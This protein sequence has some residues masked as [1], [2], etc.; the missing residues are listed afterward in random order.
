MSRLESAQVGEV[1]I[2][3]VEFRIDYFAVTFHGCSDDDVRGWLGEAFGPDWEPAGWNPVLQDDERMLKVQ[4]PHGAYLERDRSRD[5]VHVSLKGQACAAIGTEQLLS[6]A[7]ASRARCGGGF[8]P[9][10]VD[11]AWD[12]HAKRIA[13][14]EFA[15][16]VW[17]RNGTD[18]RPEV[19]SKARKGC[20]HKNLGDAK[21]ACCELGTRTSERMMRY[22]DKEA[23]SNGAVK[24]MR[25][26]LQTRHRAADALLSALIATESVSDAVSAAVSHLVGFVDFREVPCEGRGSRRRRR[27]AWWADLVGAADAA[28]IGPKTGG[29]LV[30]TIEHT[31]KQMPGP[32]AVLVAVCGSVGKAAELLVRRAG[33]PLKN[34]RLQRHVEAVARGLVT[35]EEWVDLRRLVGVMPLN[36]GSRGRQA[37]GSKARDSPPCPGPPGS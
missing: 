29:D 19:M 25:L 1:S 12:D 7:R 34:R 30:R 36:P 26:E 13:P 11:V 22:Y 5:Y 14:Q 32:F 17:E 27:C 23:Q 3:A 37:P 8:K 4:G 24:A 16:R 33:G 18:R 9:T 2:G 35:P 28:R 31:L 6:F 21:G 15:A 10:R 20:L